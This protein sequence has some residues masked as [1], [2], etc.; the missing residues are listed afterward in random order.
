[1]PAALR[2]IPVRYT[3]DEDGTV[4]PDAVVMP[5]TGAVLEIERIVDRTVLRGSRKPL[6][7]F[8]VAYRFTDGSTHDLLYDGRR[9]Y[10]AA[11]DN[12]CATA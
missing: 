10:L 11:S 9:F 12:G 7:R 1:M 2:P 3:V 4:T 8:G 5:K 6:L